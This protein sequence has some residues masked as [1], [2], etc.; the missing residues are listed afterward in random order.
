MP[1]YSCK[2]TLGVQ[3]SSNHKATAVYTVCPDVS[4]A[5]GPQ[6]KRT[7]VTDLLKDVTDVPKST[8]MING[9]P[10]LN[11]QLFSDEKENKDGVTAVC[12]KNED[13]VT[14]VQL[15]RAPL[16]CS[17]GCMARI[18]DVILH[19]VTVTNHAQSERHHVD[20]ADVQEHTQEYPLMS[21]F[22]SSNVEF[23]DAY[24]GNISNSQS[25]IA[26]DGCTRGRGP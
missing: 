14:D 7:T 9:K 2:S 15:A 1:E 11:S 20:D 3:N 26:N 6:Q 23:N 19:Q 5:V 12:T 17:Q 4:G 21:S 13:D 10:T 24:A 25:R 8:C 16:A 22:T 18:R